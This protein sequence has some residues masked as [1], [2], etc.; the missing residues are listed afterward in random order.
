MEI[1][2]ASIEHRTDGQPHSGIPNIISKA[3]RR[4]DTSV[5]KNI[6]DKHDTS[7]YISRSRYSFFLIHKNINLIYIYYS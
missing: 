7:Y 1:E 5:A 2:L 4:E 6:W 3:S